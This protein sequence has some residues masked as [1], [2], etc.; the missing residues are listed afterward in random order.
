LY[1]SADRNAAQRLAAA[2]AVAALHALAIWA[3]ATGLA[4]RAVQQVAQQ[5][6]AVDLP[7][8]RPS[9]KPSPSPKPMPKPREAA[10]PAGAA[11]PE[12]HKA[13]DVVIAPPVMLPL[14]EVIP[15]A[16][17]VGSG[18]GATGSGSGS[19]GAGNGNGSGTGGS[20]TGSGGGGVAVHARQIRGELS[21]SD[22]PSDLRK[23]GIGGQVS[24]AVTIGASG[25]VD[26]CKV[27]R[28]SG[29]PRLDEM[30]CQLVRERYVFTPARDAAGR[31]TPDWV[32]ETHV[33][34]S[35]HKPVPAQVPPAP[36]PEGQ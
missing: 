11:A 24:I 22:Y 30:T 4:G 28:G 36:V 10:R 26:D 2:L 31:P 8:D 20:G 25:R 14:P 3:L 5:L 18:S 16:P 32:H 34:W 35:G 15:A 17:V 21:R 33:W 7:L 29:V 19:G 6:S 12:G 27:V 1:R 9:P 23:A 13:P